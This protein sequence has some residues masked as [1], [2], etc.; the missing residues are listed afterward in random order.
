ML[1]LSC[2]EW[3]ELDL[4]TDLSWN[5]L[6]VTQTL[7]NRVTGEQRRASVGWGEEG[8]HCKMYQVHQNVKYSKKK[9]KKAKTNWP[10]W[11]MYHIF[12]L[13][14]LHGE[15]RQTG[16][17]IKMLTQYCFVGLNF[18]DHV[19]L[20]NGGMDHCHFYFYWN[21]VQRKETDSFILEMELYC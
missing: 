1:Q 13:I 5:G 20:V 15:T 17:K 14:S 7:S 2:R 10:Q 12:K 8:E 4:G 19:T 6:R 9:K 11:D 16:S 3:W 21:A 18:G